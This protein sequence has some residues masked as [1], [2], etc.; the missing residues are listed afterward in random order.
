MWKIVHLRVDNSWTGSTR[1]GEVK[2]FSFSLTVYME[3]RCPYPSQAFVWIFSPGSHEIAPPPPPFPVVLSRIFRDRERWVDG[4]SESCSHT[5]I[6]TLTPIHTVNSWRI[7]CCWKKKLGKF[8]SI[9]ALKRE[10]S[11]AETF[12]SQRYAV[13]NSGSIKLGCTAEEKNA[14][15]CTE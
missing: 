7:Y 3:I 2:W 11:A 8:C 15:N 12:L 13:V 4:T 14:G 1:Q 9:G 5:Y 6:G 10:K